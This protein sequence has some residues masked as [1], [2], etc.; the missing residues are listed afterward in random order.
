MEQKV[1]KYK[2]EVY[3]SGEPK[4][5]NLDE[6]VKRLIS[7]GWTI[8]QISTCTTNKYFANSGTETYLYVFLLAEKPE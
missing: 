1:F 2:F 5:Y 6:E 4:G 3:Q 8:K 7:D